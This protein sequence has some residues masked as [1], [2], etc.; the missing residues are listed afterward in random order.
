MYLLLCPAYLREIEMCSI[1]VRQVY[2]QTLHRGIDSTEE[3]Y[4]PLKQ[5]S[6]LH[7]TAVHSLGNSC[8]F[9]TTHHS[10]NVKFMQKAVTI[11]QKDEIS[12]G[13]MNTF[14]SGVIYLLFKTYTVL[15][16]IYVNLYFVGRYNRNNR[17]VPINRSSSFYR[18]QKTEYTA[19]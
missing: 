16:S 4:C 8:R 5:V 12:P 9:R 19:Y 6:L 1:I 7:V 10:I 11:L 2:S 18:F 15:R 14:N 17:Q 3:W 13:M